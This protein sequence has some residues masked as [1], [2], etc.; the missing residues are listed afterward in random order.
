M[1]DSTSNEI[2]PL[3]TALLMAQVDGDLSASHA[4]N[5]SFI[6]E[7]PHGL[8]CETCGAALTIGGVIDWWDSGYGGR[9]VT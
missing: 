6:Y 5:G 7:W 4:Q 1:T 9:D 8:K 3:T 2:D